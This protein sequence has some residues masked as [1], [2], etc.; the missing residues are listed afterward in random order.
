MTSHFPPNNFFVCYYSKSPEIFKASAFFFNGK[1]YLT[2]LEPLLIVP[3]LLGDEYKRIY[4]E[5]PFVLNI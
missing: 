3:E 4:F 5:K 2:L 1:I